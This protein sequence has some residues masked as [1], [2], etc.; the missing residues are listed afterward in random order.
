MSN[1]VVSAFKRGQCRCGS[2]DLAHQTIQKA[3]PM[4]KGTEAFI[5]C[6]TCD[7]W[8]RLMTV[9]PVETV[10]DTGIWV[11]MEAGQGK[12]SSDLEREDTIVFRNENLYSYR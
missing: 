3:G 9:I 6:R 11:L 8:E 4:R 1:Q 7:Y 5:V 2:T 12:F 10:F